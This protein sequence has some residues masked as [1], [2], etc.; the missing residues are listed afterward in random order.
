M[1]VFLFVFVVWPLWPFPYLPSTGLVTLLVPN[2]IGAN[3]QSDYFEKTVNELLKQRYKDSINQA[4]YKLLWLGG[5][6]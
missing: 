3:S 6:F 2:S 5:K 1:F 4:F